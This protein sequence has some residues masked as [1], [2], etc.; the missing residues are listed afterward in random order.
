MF[1]TEKLRRFLLGVVLWASP[2]AGIDGG[3]QY[4]APTPVTTCGQSVTGV[5]A[6]TA[7]LDC[8]AV[9]GPAIILQS[10][11]RL[12]MASFTLT[13]NDIG[14]RCEVGSCKINGPGTVRRTTLDSSSNNYGLLGF[15]RAKIDGVTFE[16]WHFGLVVLGRATVF[17]ATVLTNV[18][19]AV[20]SPL[21]VTAS[22]FS[23]N[24]VAAYGSDATKDGVRYKFYRAV[25][26]DSSFGTDTIDIAAFRRPLVVGTT[27]T[28]SAHLTVPSTPY[29]GGD[30]WGVCQ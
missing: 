1:R 11:A 23:G 7:D 21:H 24:T 13:G 19:G 29:G 6:L 2:A 9:P 14:I 12:E 16:N 26:R 20:G 10:G 28:T 3:A 27:C 4:I 18:Y 5:G 15:L 8:S 17:N 22:S 25:I 30:E